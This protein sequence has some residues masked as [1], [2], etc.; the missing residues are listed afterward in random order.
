VTPGGEYY[1]RHHQYQEQTTLGDQEHHQDHH[2]DPSRHESG[3][4]QGEQTG[5]ARQQQML[6]VCSPVVSSTSHPEMKGM[7][8]QGYTMRPGS[9]GD[10]IGSIITMLI[11]DQGADLEDILTDSRTTEDRG[12]CRER[13][14]PGLQIHSAPEIKEEG[15]PGEQ[16]SS[17]TADFPRQFP[18]PGYSYYTRSQEY[19]VTQD[20]GDKDMETRSSLSSNSEGDETDLCRGYGRVS[21]YSGSGGMMAASPYL[22][23]RDTGGHHGGHHD[24]GLASPGPGAKKDDK[25]W[26]RRRK[27]NLAAKKSRDARRVRE[28]QLRLRVLCLENANRVLREQMDRKDVEL[29]QLRERLSKYET[30]PQPQQMTEQHNMGHNNNP[31]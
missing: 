27:N 31:M 1:P 14:E 13:L 30:V 26:E 5:Q 12:Q 3:D 18:S 6:E 15:G 20:Q 4:K 25:Y 19:C 21:S 23:T 8:G 28:N 7:R 22:V 10:N 2:Q 24:T 16:L 9:Q 29:I 17:V 11:D